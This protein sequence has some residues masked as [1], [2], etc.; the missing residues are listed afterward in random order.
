MEKHIG[1]RIKTCRWG[2]T[3]IRVMCQLFSPTT[4]KKENENMSRKKNDSLS[5]EV[6]NRE[7]ANWV[8][9]DPVSPGAWD[10]FF[11]VT[12]KKMKS[13]YDVTMQYLSQ[14]SKEQFDF[15]CEG[16]EEVVHHFQKLEMVE[17]IESQYHNFY[18]ES[19]DTEFYHNN[20][21]CLKN[22]IK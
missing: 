12:I 17:L 6:L 1:E 16:I 3:P 11:T 18:G 21:E 10:M 14:I 7:I 9:Q 22:C 15:V 13:D 5:V 2:C 19:K 4:T 20:I 8:E